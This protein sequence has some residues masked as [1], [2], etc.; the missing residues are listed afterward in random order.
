MHPLYLS[1]VKPGEETF[2]DE[3]PFATKPFNV[4]SSSAPS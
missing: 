4:R 3:P 1:R 2:I